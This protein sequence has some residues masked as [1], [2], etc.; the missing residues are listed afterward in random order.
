MADQNTAVQGAEFDFD[1][2]RGVE[3]GLVR[4]MV[5]GGA[6]LIAPISASPITK[7]T[8]DK[9]LLVEQ[10][11]FI[12]LGRI[13]KDGAPTFNADVQE[14]TVETWGEMEPSRRDITTSTLTVEATLQDTRKETLMLAARRDMEYMKQ[15]KPGTNGEFGIV[16]NPQPGTQ[17]FQMLMIGADGTGEDAFYFGRYLPRVSIKIGT[18]S[19][20]PQSEVTYPLTATA[21]KHTKLGF[22]S[23]RFYG[24]PGAKARLKAMGF[25]G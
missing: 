25:S 13:A 2:F 4:K 10:A 20:N 12:G 17:F 11:G 19:W 6:I 1:K 18:E 21:T 22:S 8:D 3:D 23:K 5:S 24:G 7:F 16:D 9:G 15:V 14:D